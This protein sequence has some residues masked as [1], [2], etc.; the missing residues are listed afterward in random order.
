[1]PASQDDV[2]AEMSASTGAHRYLSAGLSGCML[3]SVIN[4]YWSIAGLFLL[5][6]IPRSRRAC[7]GAMV[8]QRRVND[9][10]P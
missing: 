10:K 1:V 9:L 7:A 6:L 3:L 2:N 4:T 8:E 5:Q